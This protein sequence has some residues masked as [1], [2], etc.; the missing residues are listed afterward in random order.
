[1]LEIKPAKM[2]PITAM[3]LWLCLV[4]ALPTQSICQLVWPLLSFLVRILCCSL[5]LPLFLS[6]PFQT[7]FKSHAH[8]F[9]FTNGIIAESDPT[10]LK[11][12]DFH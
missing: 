12:F 6:L 7:M 2:T 3:L 5:F 10:Y 11:L 4:E 1:M 9:H 8:P